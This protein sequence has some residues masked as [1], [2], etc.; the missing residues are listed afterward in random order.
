MKDIYCT[1]SAMDFFDIKA[2]DNY[3]G[4]EKVLGNQ[5]YSTPLLRPIFRVI[6]N[7]Y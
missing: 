4:W 2:F 3:E 7:S 1:S 5:S 6:R